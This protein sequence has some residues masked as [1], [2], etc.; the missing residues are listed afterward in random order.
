M[1]TGPFQ[2]NGFPLRRVNPRYV[3]ATSSKVPLD[4]V[5]VSKFDD[6]FFNKSK[7]PKEHAKEK[8][9]VFMSQ[10]CPK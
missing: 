8:E 10:V 7:K 6:A 3:V 1:I 2:V 9:T 5:D 4:N